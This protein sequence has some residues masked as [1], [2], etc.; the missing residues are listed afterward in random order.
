MIVHFNKND[1]SLLFFALKMSHN[2]KIEDLS[3]MHH[4]QFTRKSENPFKKNIH[5]IQMH[6]FINNRR[7]K[8]ACGFRICLYIMFAV[9]VLHCGNTA[10]AEHGQGYSHSDLSKVNILEQDT[11]VHRDSSKGISRRFN[12][13]TSYVK[14]RI[15]QVSIS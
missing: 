6:T 2:L 12:Q 7:L 1:V 5:V 11:V 10:A 13:L 15:N 14:L 9:H 4:I 8:L 3:L